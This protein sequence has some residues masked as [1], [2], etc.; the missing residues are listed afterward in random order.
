M[1]GVTVAV[2]AGYEDL[3]VL[4]DG[5]ERVPLQIFPSLRRLR[6]VHQPVS[7]YEQTK[8]EL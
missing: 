2:E 7:T 1:P 3:V 6:A 5:V 4:P 8:G